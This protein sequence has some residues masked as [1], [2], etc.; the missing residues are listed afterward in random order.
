M[1]EDFR[2][3]PITRSDL[4]SFLPNNR[5]IRAFEKLFEMANDIG[6]APIF[7]SVANITQPIELHDIEKDRDGFIN[8][9]FSGTEFTIYS[10]SN[11]QLTENVPYVISGKSGSWIAI[12]GKYLN[13][14]FNT[15]VI[16]TN[17]I[18][19]VLGF[20]ETIDSTSIYT[21]LL[22]AIQVKASYIDFDLAPIAI[23]Q[24][25][26]LKWNLDDGTL[27]TGL[28]GGN[29]NLQIGFELLVKV[30]NKSGSLITN[31]AAVYVD[32]AQGSRPTINLA[33][34]DAEATAVTFI[35]LA[36]EDIPNN[37]NGYICVN[38]LVRDIDTS[39]F[40]E[41]SILYLSSATAGQYTATRPT[42]PNWKIGIGVCLYSHANQGIVGVVPRINPNLNRLQDVY[43][44][45]PSDGHLLIYDGTTS[46][47]R[48]SGPKFGDINGGN[49]TEFETDGTKVSVGNATTFRD[50]YTAL[51]GSRLESPSSHITQSNAEGSLVFDTSCTLSDYVIMNPQLNHDRKLGS[52]VDIHLHWWQAS[53]TMPNW[54]IQYRWQVNGQAKTT[55]WTSVKW[56]SNAFTYSAGTLNQITSFGLI[57]PPSPDSLSDI[58]QIRLL[59]D[60]T[61]ASGLF[62]ASDA[63]VASVHA[64]SYDVHIEMDTDGSRQRYIK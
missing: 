51:I 54:L 23:S 20:I 28:P 2:P 19:A 39:A 15:T 49:Y 24:E 27:E 52:S 58:L 29:V 22:D 6:N 7:T 62:A 32:G 12:G 5:A 57:T 41:G 11:T 8:I 45:S 55:A 3:R 18:N 31:G 64:L 44:S 34:A 26:R 10:F 30:T 56:S 47:Y 40:T 4:A 43:N 13:S 38:G 21:D 37:G 42:A 35:G 17:T 61:N 53:S 36:T 50:E 25:G 9:V 16:N 60:T 14:D 63:L 1:A 33:K 46:R 48:N 59:R